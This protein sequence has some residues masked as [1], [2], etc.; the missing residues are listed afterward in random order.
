MIKSNFFI[1]TI[2]VISISSYLF[3]NNWSKLVQNDI[4]FNKEGELFFYSKVSKIKNKSITI[5]IA[6][7][8]QE[9]NLGLMNRKDL[10]NNNGMLFIYKTSYKRFF[11]MKNTYIPLDI[12]YVNENFLIVSIQ[13]NA[14]PLDESKYPSY[15]KAMYVVEVNAGFCGKHNIRVGDSISYN[16]I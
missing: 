4:D 10:R 16:R 1:F 15:K 8:R 13:K 14:K 5:E 7:N 6:E 11:W 9:R 2:I 12:I 3:F